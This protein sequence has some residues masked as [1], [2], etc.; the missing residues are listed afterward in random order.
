MAR[1]AKSAFC[2]KFSEFW[3]I[4]EFSKMQNNNLKIIMTKNK[5]KI[6]NGALFKLFFNY[7]IIIIWGFRNPENPQTSEKFRK[8]ATRCDFA[9][10][11]IQTKGPPFSASA[12][13]V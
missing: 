13:K 9:L 1:K 4:A 10:H 11:T 5:Y 2:P 12:R 3:E 7:V 6:T 8:S